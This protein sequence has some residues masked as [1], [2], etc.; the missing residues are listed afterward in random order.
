MRLSRSLLLGLLALLVLPKLYAQNLH[1]SLNCGSGMIETTQEFSTNPQPGESYGWPSGS[2]SQTYANV[3]MSGHQVSINFSGSTD[4][5]TLLNGLQSP[6]VDASLNSYTN[7]IGLVT[8]GIGVG[9]RITVTFDIFPPAPGEVAFEVFH[10]NRSGS[11][12]LVTVTAETTTG[13]TITPQITVPMGAA[14][15]NIISPGVMDAVSFGSLDAGQAGVNFSSPDSISRVTL[16]W[17]ECTTCPVGFHGLSFGKFS[18][19]RKLIDND[20]D[21]IED[22]N[23]VDDDN[24]G[25]LDIVE[26]C[27]VG[28]LTVDLD[29]IDITVQLDGYPEETSW[30]LRDDLGTLLSSGG[31]YAN[32]ADIGRV[33]QEQV[34]VDADRDFFFEIYDS[35]GDALTSSPTGGYSLD[36]NGTTVVPFNTSAWG[37]DNTHYIPGQGGGSGSGFGCLG[38]DYA[39]DSDD[40]GL[41]NYQDPDF[42]SLNSRG[43]CS[44]LDFDGDGVIDPFDKDADNDGIWDAIEAQ[45]SSCFVTPSSGVDAFGLPINLVS[46]ANCADNHLGNTYG[47]IP[48]IDADDIDLNPDY[49]DLNTDG[50][51]AQDQ[52]EGFDFNGDSAAMDDFLILGAAF[53]SLNGSPAIYI[54]VDSDND[55]IP[56]WL[57]NLPASP[58]EDPDSPLPFLDPNSVWYWDTDN[59]G[60]VDLL[61][62]DNGGTTP[63]YPPDIDGDA[64]PDWRDSDFANNL[65]VEIISFEVLGSGSP[66]AD[67]RWTTENSIDLDYFMVM[68]KKLGGEFVEIARVRNG[69]GSNWTYL[70]N[71][72]LGAKTSMYYQVVGV[73]RD[74]VRNA[75]IIQEWQPN[76]EEQGLIVN[77]FPQ[78]VKDHLNIEL[79]G[80]NGPFQITLFDSFGR[81]LRTREVVGTHRAK[82]RMDLN[83]LR[84]GIYILKVNSGP[85]TRTFKLFKAS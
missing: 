57:D 61:D 49:I 53:S 5:L 24:D 78:P 84:S 25:I 37:F 59:D 75:S 72:L 63:A 52:I 67:L 56:D 50:D 20:E 29:T 71:G 21:G 79:I 38:G 41:F 8:T 42:C 46:Y 33:I 1:Q 36:Y 4:S 58:G 10:I 64:D 66:Q 31:P 45:G 30:I 81:E 18:F 9:N 43:V 2:L 11:G 27:G 70:D 60:M 55:L 40:D 14:S 28:A 12:D 83:D 13:A 82:L 65:P 15:Y 3:N 68:R 32:P 6:T 80:E 51:L 34:L 22:W 17:E 35:F 73:D 7:A 26:S 74:G 62:P 23:D 76:T 69:S 77:V 19:C 16:H 85:E 39:L 54:S 44:I 47:V 48:N